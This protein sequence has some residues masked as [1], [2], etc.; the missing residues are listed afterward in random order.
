[1]FCG[2]EYKV[3]FRPVTA[4]EKTENEYDSVEAGGQ[5]P[6]TAHVEHHIFFLNSGLL[7]QSAMRAETEGEF[8]WTYHVQQFSAWSPVNH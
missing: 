6:I 8:L 2:C 5:N 4:G 3:T 1:M 7:M